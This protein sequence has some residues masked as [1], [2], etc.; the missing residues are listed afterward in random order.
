MKIGLLDVDG[1]NFPNLPLMKISAWHKAKGDHV[2]PFFGLFRYDKVYVSK[3]FTSSRDYE[4]AIQADEVEYGGTGYGLENKLPAEIEH[5]YPDYSLY[6]MNRSAYGFLTRGCPRACPFCIVGEKEGKISRQVADLSESWR[7]QKEIVLLDPNLLA[8]RD[9]EKLLD[10]LIESKAKVDFTQGLDA[11]LITPEIAKMLAKVN[12]KMVHFA[13]DFIADEHEVI[14][15]LAE[16]KKA[17]NIDQRQAAVYML[18]NYN[19]THEEDMYRLLK[20]R[21][22]GFMPDVRI[23]NKDQAPKITRYLQT[24]CN[25]RKSYY[26]EPDFYMFRPSKKSDGKTVREILGLQEREMVKSEV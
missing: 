18:T 7:G 13:W 10:Q 19:T 14:R 11:R 2:E 15:G 21:E 16:Y 23:Y 4:F 20:I 9:R 22:L 3:V 26:A 25:G 1:H 17:T 12:T 24:W 8:C 6:R 5:I